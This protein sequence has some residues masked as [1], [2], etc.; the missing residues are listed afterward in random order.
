MSTKPTTTVYWHDSF[1]AHKPSDGEFEREW[2]G[3]LAVHEPHP[4]RPARVRNIRSILNEALSPYVSWTEAPEATREQLVH[5]H[6]PSYIDLFQEFCENGGG[7]LTQTTG[8]NEAS[9]G[10]AIRAAG[11]AVQAAVDTLKTGPRHVPY[12]LVR[13]SGHHAQPQQADGFC[14]FNNVAIAAE[15]VLTTTSAARVAVIDWDV[16]HGNGTQE[17][18]YDRDDVLVIDL[19]NDHG[20]WHPQ[21]HPQTGRHNE[22][23][24]GSGIGYTVNLPLPPG[25]GNAGYAAAFD[26][27]VEPAVHAFD[28]DLLLVS[29]GQD[30]GIIDP[31]GRNLVTKGG[32]KSLGRRARELADDCTDGSLALVQ[33]GGYQISH[34]AYATLGVLE[35][36]LKVEAG[37]DDPFE[38][39]HAEFDPAR[40]A[41]DETIAVYADHWPFDP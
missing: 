22:R 39:L 20:S 3:R 15:H 35:G 1:L 27:I 19:H 33:E 2:T 37:I 23:G 34:L 17:C 24:T 40:T 29:A 36:V 41:I 7:R 12:A 18:F 11:A 28:P 6:E 21:A 4:D 9:Y 14:F 32:F 16:H 13:P 5:V 8:A 31:L 25:T 38:W 10:A 30:P 26:Q